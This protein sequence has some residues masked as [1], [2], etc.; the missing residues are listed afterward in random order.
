MGGIEKRKTVRVT[1]SR[2]FC[3]F[4]SGPGGG[5]DVAWVC[6]CVCEREKEVSLHGVNEG[7]FI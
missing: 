6:V 7:F 2:S 4:L 3:R 1:W 5:V